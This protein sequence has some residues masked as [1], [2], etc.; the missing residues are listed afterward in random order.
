MEDNL[1]EHD[2]RLVGQEITPFMGPE[3]SLPCSQERPIE[4]SP[5]P[6]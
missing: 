5:E 4:S 2:C 3:V 1:W 6:D